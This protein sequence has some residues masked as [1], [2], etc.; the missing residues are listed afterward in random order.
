MKSYNWIYKELVTNEDDLVGAIAYSLYKRH[1]IEYI[2]QCVAETGEPPTDE[3]LAE[4]RRTSSSPT[5][6][7]SYRHKADMLLSN[8]LSFATEN[9]ANEMQ[10]Q[11]KEVI[12]NELIQLLKPIQDEIAKKKGV[13]QMIFEAF[14]SVF[15]TVVVFILVGLLLKGYQ[16]ISSFTVTPTS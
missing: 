15:G 6:L 1:K 9:I 16:L 14:I 4:F 8:L 7:E 10:K 12:N 2:N 5:S 11:N 13:G 3:Q